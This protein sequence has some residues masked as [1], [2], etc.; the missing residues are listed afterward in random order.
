LERASLNDQILDAEQFGEA[1]LHAI[2]NGRKVTA[3]PE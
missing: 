1:I 3:I 2:R